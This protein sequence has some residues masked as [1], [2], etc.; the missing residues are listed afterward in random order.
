MNAYEEL[1]D[2]EQTVVDRIALFALV[3]GLLEAAEAAETEHEEA[4]A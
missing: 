3:Y 2:E 4:A 1:S